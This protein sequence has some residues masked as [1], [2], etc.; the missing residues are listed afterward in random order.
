MILAVCEVFRRGYTRPAA[1]IPTGAGKSMLLGALVRA[2]INT[3][4]RH[5]L[6]QQVLVLTSRTNLVK[7]FLFTPDEVSDEENDGAG[8]DIGEARLWL[9]DIPDTSIRT[10]VSGNLT[11]REY[12]DELV[13]DP[14]VTFM[15]YYGFNEKTFVENFKKN[16]GLILLDECHNVTERVADLIN[17]T[18]AFC[19]GVSGTV[20]GPL[21]RSPYF[22]FDPVVS[23]EDQ[24]VQV[25]G[26]NYKRFLSY[27]KS[28]VELIQEG[29]LKPVRWI[30]ARTKI[31]IS[32]ADAVRW[33]AQ[34]ILNEVS[35]SRIIGKNPHLGFEVLKE[36][37]L[38]DDRLLRDLGATGVIDRKGIGFT[39][40]VADAQYYADMCNKEL[41]PAIHRVYGPQKHFCA[42]YVDGSMDR[43]T[44][45]EQMRKFR[46][47]E[48]TLM[49]SCEKLGEGL[50]IPNINLVIMLR[51]YGLGSEWK[52]KQALGRGMRFS[53]VPNEDLLV[54]DGVFQSR[55]HN[56]AS[57]LGIFGQYCVFNGGLIAAPQYYHAVEQKILSMRFLG[58]TWEKILQSLTHEER[59]RAPYL[60]ESLKTARSNESQSTITNKDIVTR[61]KIEVSFVEK[62][63]VRYTIALGNKGEMLKLAK[64]ELEERGYSISR[65]KYISG[66][67]TIF[68]GFLR[69]QF[70]VFHTGKH[71]I[72]SV[73]SLESETITQATMNMFLGA[74]ERAGLQTEKTDKG[75]TDVDDL[76]KQSVETKQ[77]Q[78]VGSMKVERIN[79]PKQVFE[80]DPIGKLNTFALNHFGVIPLI[81]VNPRV[82]FGQPDIFAGQ[83][84]MTFMGNQFQTDIVYGGNSVTARKLASVQLLAILR[85][86]TANDENLFYDSPTFKQNLNLLDN[87]KK[88]YRFDVVYEEKAVGNFTEVIAQANING[89]VVR[90]DPIAHASYKKARR[91]ACVMLYEQLIL[92]MPLLCG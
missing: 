30:E 9:K 11:S 45:D 37:Y 25:V 48:I 67:K 40:C 20:Q 32:G 41:M 66:E 61:A 68:E 46:E 82:Q 12:R 78:L 57:V 85:A 39:V 14:L 38:S 53:G 73:L 59:M 36:I 6:T 60:V 18:S 44:F 16:I 75:K 31:D 3:I 50:N 62:R 91:L 51:P 69:R 35:V 2:Y 86:Y 70:G 87:L 88:T 17:K 49:F 10:L 90:S 27:H 77:P 47:G 7:Q 5:G 23:D 28:M 64:E 33:G 83:A 80:E 22:F 21:M 81:E 74:M 56:L 79:A 8:L 43:E 65:L 71:M 15:T 1:E 63:E 26:A 92:V 58:M 4:R 72:Q 52:M 29:Q 13:K 54:V 55:R 34:T 42:S 19:I 76:S 84:S 24:G 89:S